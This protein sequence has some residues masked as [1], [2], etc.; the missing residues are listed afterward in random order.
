MRLTLQVLAGV[1]LATGLWLAIAPG[2]FAHN[3]APFG[4]VDHHF[5]RDIATAY[6]AMGAALWLSAGRP[7]WRVPVLFLVTLQYA[8]HTLNHLLDIGGTDP[9]WKGYFNFVSLAF[10]TVALGYVLAAAARAETGR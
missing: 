7:S 2:N 5:L 4:P 10:L 8:I 9:A 3:V 6:L 1:Q